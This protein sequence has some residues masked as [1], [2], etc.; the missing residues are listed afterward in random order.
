MTPPHHQII[1]NLLSVSYIS[2]FL[3]LHMN[4]IIMCG[5]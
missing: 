3:D 1:T 2:P 5:L 4:G